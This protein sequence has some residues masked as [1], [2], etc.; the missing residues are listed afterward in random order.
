LQYLGQGDNSE[1]KIYQTFADTFHKENPDITIQ[2]AFATPGGSAGVLQKLETL[3]AANSG[4]D[5]YWTHSFIG[6]ALNKQGISLVLDPFLQQD[7]T[8]KLD[9]YFAAAYLDYTFDGKHTALPREIATNIMYY[10]TDLFDKAG[11][12]YPDAN[13]T[14]DDMR[15]AA[16]KLT[17]GQ[18]GSKIYGFGGPVTSSFMYRSMSLEKGSDIVDKQNLKSLFANQPVIDAIQYFADYRSKDHTA[19]TTADLTADKNAGSFQKGLAAIAFSG[20]YLIG[21]IKNDTTATWPYDCSNMP[22]FSGG[23]RYSASATSA[24]SAWSGTKHSQ[25][26][27]R[28]VKYLSGPE[29]SKLYGA[30]GLVIPPL[31][32]LAESDQFTSAADVPH[33]RKAF[34][35]DLTNAEAFPIVPNWIDVQN[36]FGAVLQPVWDGK[37]TAKEAIDAGN[38]KINAELQKNA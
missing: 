7:K 2:I 25:E 32:A 12:K 33:H 8:I 18:S 24:H 11:I 38:G 36:V 21:V 28:W 26:A 22:I 9:D 14:W 6:A 13:W 23:K 27:W 16:Q 5:A 31:K 29:A 1:L 15:D 37:M 17:S 20:Y 30:L 35:D 34:I 19:P 3:V 4:P 10:R